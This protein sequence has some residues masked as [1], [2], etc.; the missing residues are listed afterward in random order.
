MDDAQNN[1]NIRLRTGGGTQILMDDTTGSI[2]VITKNGK[3]W[4]ELDKNGNIN[5]FSVKAL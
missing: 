5:F 3:A 1:S 2:Y 4:F